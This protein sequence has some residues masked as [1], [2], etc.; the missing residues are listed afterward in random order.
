MSRPDSFILLQNGERRIRT[1]EG[2]S[3]QIYSLIPLATWVSPRG[4]SSVKNINNTK[5]TFL[6]ASK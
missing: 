6:K 3:R 4:I 1:S 5:K 2:K